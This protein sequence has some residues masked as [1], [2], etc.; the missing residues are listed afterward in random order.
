MSVAA[1]VLEDGGSEDEAIAGLLHDAVEDQGGRVIL[2]QIRQAFGEPV[3]LIIDGCT[4]TYEVPKPPW[5]SRKEQYLE[6]LKSA[7]A[8]VR[9]V[10][11]ADKLH[12]ARAILADL[13]TIGEEVWIRFNGGKSGTL[14][15]YRSLAELF[16]TIS[17]S[18]MV[19]ELDRTV[20]E[21]ETLAGLPGFPASRA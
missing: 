11:L 13:K 5:R 3:A 1:L 20:S 12:N 7:S 15:Y 10:S 4:D 6:H 16:K 17:S 8:G 21:I 2:D 14:W 18:P 9:R 19:I